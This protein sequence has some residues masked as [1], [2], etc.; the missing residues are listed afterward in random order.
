MV[1]V[2]ELHYKKEK[3]NMKILKLEEI[4]KVKKGW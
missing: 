3:F 1:F 2:M 4:N